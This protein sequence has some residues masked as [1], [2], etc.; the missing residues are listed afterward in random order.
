VKEPRP[1]LLARAAPAA[2]LR[3]EGALVCLVA[4][5]IFLAIPLS[6]GELGLG[7]DALNHHIYLGWT[8]QQHRFDRDFLGAGYQA[9]TFPYLYW[10]L[11]QMAAAGWSGVAVGVTLAALNGVLVAPPVWLL[12]RACMPGATWFDLAM[13]V[14]GVAL[15]FLTGVALSVLGATMNDLLAA[16][17]LLWAVA[18]A[19]QAMPD[20]GSDAKAVRWP[21]LFSG[22]CAG[23][24]V[25]AKLSN[26]PLAILMPGLWWLCGRGWRPQVMA[27]ALGSAAT[28]VGFAAL[29]GYWGWLLWCYFGNPIFPFHHHWFEPLRRWAGMG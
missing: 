15:A 25:A 11:Y 2:L 28:L 26:G 27:V 12:A 21:V 5:G 18:L 14:L 1:P 29:Y 6:L 10:P 13:R 19:V 3:W 22:L 8:A 20:A 9:Y 23:A 17:P 16:A 4:W 7:W 24:A